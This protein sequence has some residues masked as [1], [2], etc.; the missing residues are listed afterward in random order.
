MAVIAG[1]RVELTS[2]EIERV[3]ARLE[4][5]THRGALR[6]RERPAL[7]A[8]AVDRGGDGA[9]SSGLQQPP[10]PRRP[11]ATRVHGRQ[12]ATGCRREP[13]GWRPARRGRSPL[14]GA[15]RGTMGGPKWS[16][17]PVRR[18]LA[19]GRG[20]VAAPPRPQRAGVAGSNR[21]RAGRVGHQFPALIV[22]YTELPGS[23]G[24][25][26]RPVLDI[27]VADVASILVPCLVD[28]GSLNTLLP[29]WSADVA[30]LDLTA[31]EVRRL[32]V[33]GT[34]VARGLCSLDFPRLD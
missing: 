12:E 18:G 31:G 6:R 30:G 32:A 22:A 20:P 34:A 21:L 29:S 17:D 11:A 10:G 33:G 7:P 23:V 24:S 28:S 19:P 16:R 3:A 5:R 1:Q 13:Y 15:V 25:A 2:E 14:A 26:P 8:E 27:T 4:A 9:R